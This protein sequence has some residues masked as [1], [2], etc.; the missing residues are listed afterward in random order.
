KE[1]SLVE[2]KPSGTTVKV[3]ERI[4]LTIKYRLTGA[5]TQPAGE[6]VMATIDVL[7]PQPIRLGTKPWLVF[8]PSVVHNLAE[9][10][11]TVDAQ[12]TKPGNYT[13]RIVL[14]ARGYQ[15]TIYKSVPFRVTAGEY[16][17][18]RIEV[19][20]SYRPAPLTP[21]ALKAGPAGKKTHGAA[22]RS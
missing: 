16:R 14:K 20:R 18:A 1:L 13:W 4:A 12:F 15:Q 21:K 10:V 7:G 6:T 5:R 3:G 11:K 8:S 19:T 22:E 9:D 17:L 2:A